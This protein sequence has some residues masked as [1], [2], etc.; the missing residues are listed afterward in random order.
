[1][2]PNQL[3]QQQFNR[4]KE[5]ADNAMFNLTNPRSLEQLTPEYKAAMAGRVQALTGQL[6]AANNAGLA[7]G[8]G[9]A[10]QQIQAGAENNRTA[11]LKSYW[12]GQLGVQRGQ[13]DLQKQVATQAANRPP[14][15]DI[16]TISNEYVI[17]GSR[18]DKSGKQQTVKLEQ[19]MINGV[20]QATPQQIALANDEAGIRARME[21]E[22]AGGPFG[23]KN[24]IGMGM[25]DEEI[26]ARQAELLPQFA[27]RFG[28]G[29]N[30]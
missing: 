12:D 8:G 14:K 16:R 22:E 10:Q 15:Q 4:M 17:P 25:D 9:I 2:D 18:P 27:A 11:G 1:M 24:L 21:A 23:I 7:A 26:A 29:I 3:A 19:P 28:Y 6:G 30:R 20:P 13:L 5:E